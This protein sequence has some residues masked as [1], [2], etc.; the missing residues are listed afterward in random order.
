MSTF[1]DLMIN[2][3]GLLAIGWTLAY[4]VVSMI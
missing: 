4:S 1:T 3:V 2:L